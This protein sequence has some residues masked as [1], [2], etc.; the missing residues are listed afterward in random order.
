MT[1]QD[2]P[3]MGPKSV[4]FDDTLG[5][6]RQEIEDRLSKTILKA[7]L[8]LNILKQSE[9][10][11][12]EVL[13]DLMQIEMEV[14]TFVSDVLSGNGK[15]MATELCE[16]SLSRALSFIQIGKSSQKRDPAGS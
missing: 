15:K 8:A 14:G 11:V 2:I 13:D 5:G 3:Q 7:S 10:P 6:S 4:G 1:D 16:D 12:C 9:K